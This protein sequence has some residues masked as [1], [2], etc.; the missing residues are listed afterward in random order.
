MDSEREHTTIYR[1]VVNHEEQYSIWPVDRELPLGWN[2]AGK[3]GSKEEVLAWIREV[4]VDMRPLSLRKKMEE[5]A[6]QERR[7]N[8]GHVPPGPEPDRF[9]YR[10]VKKPDG[11]YILIPF[12][13]QAFTVEPYVSS[14]WEDTGIKGT[15]EEL[16]S[17]IT[18]KGGV[19]VMLYR[20]ADDD[21]F[22]YRAV[23]RPDGL[24]I[25]LPSDDE[26]FTGE[27]YVSSGWEDTGLTGTEAELEA[28]IE[29]KGGNIVQ[30]YRHA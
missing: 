9:R 1:A 30:R 5:M 13:D 26:T 3:V 7:R 17:I 18:R 15:D 19:I 12:H 4:W 16:E 8:G 20:D 23:K 14:G 28:V 25:L 10:A 24:Y 27:L 21:R 11:F 22:R 2:D 29:R 6:E